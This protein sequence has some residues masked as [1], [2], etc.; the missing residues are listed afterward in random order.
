MPLVKDDELYIVLTIDPKPNILHCNL[1]SAECTWVTP[2][3]ALDINSRITS[4]RGGTPFI[5]NKKLDVTPENIFESMS[6][7]FAID[8]SIKLKKW[9]KVKYI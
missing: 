9:I 1:E 2:W 4:S 3:D 5:Y 8:K 6:V 7:A